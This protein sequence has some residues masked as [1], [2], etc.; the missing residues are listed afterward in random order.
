MRREGHFIRKSG[1][2]RHGRRRR[3]GPRLRSRDDPPSAGEVAAH[4]A[5]IHDDR[6]GYA[7]PANVLDEFRLVAES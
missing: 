6:R 5:E 3:L 7:I 4:F 2:H 1:S